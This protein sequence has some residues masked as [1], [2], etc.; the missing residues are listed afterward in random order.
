MGLIS[1]V[2]QEEQ[3]MVLFYIVFE[4]VLFFCF[5]VID[6]E[7][8]AERVA[9]LTCAVC[10]QQKAPLHLAACRKY[11]MARAPTPWLGLWGLDIH[12]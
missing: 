9:F 7:E 6:L 11:V 12:P 10:I 8:E 5:Q 3:R 1:R 4:G 2:Y